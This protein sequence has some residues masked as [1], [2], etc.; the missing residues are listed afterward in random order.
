M[1]KYIGKFADIATLAAA[2][3]QGSI[4]RPFVALTEDNDKV[5]YGPKLDLAKVGDIAVYGVAEDQIY[6]IKQANY[7]TTDFPT[8]D[9]VPIG[10]V[11]KNQLEEGLG[12][13]LVKVMNLKYLDFAHP[14]TGSSSPLAIKCIY[15]YYPNARGVFHPYYENG[16]EPYGADP[17]G[18]DNSNYVIERITSPED[19]MTAESLVDSDQDIYGM[20]YAL[21]W[22]WKTLGTENGE[23]YIPSCGELSDIALNSD[24]LQ[25]LNQAMTLVSGSQ[26]VL[27]QDSTG[28]FTS[29]VVRVERWENY[30]VGRNLKHDWP[31]T[32][33]S[34]GFGYRQTSSNYARAITS[35]AITEL[36]K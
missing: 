4:S 30:P 8:A 19:W 34:S 29:T 6:Y 12:Y 14:D 36:K 3:D 2:V 1:A 28:L 7:N 23:W 26:I 11:C 31:I 9:Y 18:Y 13:G 20:P 35:L 17:Y 24:N 27:S 16:S 5:V 21:A 32:T 15:E 25:K 22:R 33:R 10:V